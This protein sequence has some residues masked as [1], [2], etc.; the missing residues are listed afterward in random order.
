MPKLVKV[1]RNNYTTMNNVMWRDGNLGATE[2]GVL[3][4]MLSLPPDWDF[5]IKGLATLFPDGERK[6]GT[7]LQKIEKL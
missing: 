1:C 2:Q 6:I 3:G 4:T 5:P 7:S